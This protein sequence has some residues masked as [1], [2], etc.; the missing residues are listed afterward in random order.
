MSI[1]SNSVPYLMSVIL[2]RILSVIVQLTLCCVC[3]SP[4]LS[5]Y[6]RICFVPMRSHNEVEHLQDELKRIH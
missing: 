4:I 5:P 6:Y 3:L 2:F 1:S